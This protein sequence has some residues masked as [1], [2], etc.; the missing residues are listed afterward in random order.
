VSTID[1]LETYKADTLIFGNYNRLG[2][3][4][5]IPSGFGE[6]TSVALVYVFADV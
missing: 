2:L 1:E 4:P 3:L 6:A 5:L